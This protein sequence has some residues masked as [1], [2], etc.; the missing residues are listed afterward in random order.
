[1][2]PEVDSFFKKAKKWRKEMESLRA[3]LLDAPL[4]EELKWM[5][6]CYG[7]NENNV[8]IIQPFKEQCA[9]MFFKGVLL[10]DPE[11]LLESPGPNSRI[12]KR[13]MFSSLAEIAEKKASLRDFIAQAIEIE[14]SGRKPEAEHESE[15][16]PEE[17]LSAFDEV[18]GLKTAFEALTPGRRRAYILHFYGAKQS[19]TRR[20]RIDKCIP[21][22][23]DGKG[24]RD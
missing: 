7:Y 22:I 13:M 19:A 11:S 9:V 1:M 20:S 15:P 4:S 23:L 10:S 18:E 5:K 17:L 12:A 16:L 8:A 2:N 21:R 3:I 6:P 14:K 24:P